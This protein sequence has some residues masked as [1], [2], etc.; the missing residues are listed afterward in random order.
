MSDTQGEPTTTTV[1]TAKAEP[2]T[3]QSQTF[4]V[5]VLLILVLSGTVF[6]V[7]MKAN[8]DV[9]STIAS[10][11]IGGILTG[12]AGYYYSSSKHAPA[13]TPPGSTTTTTAA[14]QTTTTTTGTAP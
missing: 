2:E 14:P 13:T 1:A 4:I 7:F 3:L 5:S 11:V 10:L 9:Q 8:T 12:L 6:G